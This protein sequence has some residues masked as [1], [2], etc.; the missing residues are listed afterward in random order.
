MIEFFIY[1]L[2]NNFVTMTNYL[3]IFL[4]GGLGAMLRFFTAACVEKFCSAALGRVGVFPWGTV[5]VN[6][7]GCIVFGLLYTII[8]RYSHSREMSLLL[9][10][11][12]LGGYTTFSTF[13]FEGFRL[14]QAGHISAFWGD[15]LLQVGLSVPAVWLGIYLGRLVT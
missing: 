3:L 7:S 10:V 13:A 2:D 4:G 15:Y 5:I 14:I 1:I 9:L 12:V 8:D 11:G 6:L